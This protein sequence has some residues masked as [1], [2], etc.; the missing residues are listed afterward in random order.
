MG[1]RFSQRGNWI[2]LRASF[3]N[4]SLP[5][6]WGRTFGDHGKASSSTVRISFQDRVAIHGETE[7]GL[8]Q[9]RH[10]HDESA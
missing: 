4:L 10:W 7:A 1:P 5:L 9:T 2:L 3:A 6:Y 8:T